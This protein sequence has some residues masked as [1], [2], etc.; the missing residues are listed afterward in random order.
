MIP[1][2]TPLFFGVV[3]YVVAPALWL[4]WRGRLRAS[5]L[6]AAT[7]ALSALQLGWNGELATAAAC[8]GLQL[9]IIALYALVRPRGIPGAHWGAIALVL[10]P[11]VVTRLTGVTTLASPFGFLGISYVTFRVIDV[12]FGLRDG[13]IKQLDG[14]ALVAYLLFFP[15]LSSGPIDRYRRFAADFRRTLSREA[16]LDLLDSAVPLFVRGALYKFVGAALVKEQLVDRLVD[17]GDLLGIGGYMYA[18]TAFLFLDFAGYSAMA[19]ALSRVFGINTP[20]NFNRPFLATNIVEFWN[21]WHISLSTW[22]RDHVYMR[23]VLAAKRGKWFSDRYVPSY[24]ALVVSFGLMGIWHGFA[25]HFVV[26]GL[27]HAMLQ[28]GHSL[29]VRWNAKHRVWG[30][31]RGWRLLGQFVTVNAYCL[32]LLLFSGRLF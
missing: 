32:G 13:A 27:Y 1:Y 4:G 20:E 11:L 15:T 6:L 24:L 29:F 5:F 3:G 16:Y 18:Y 9:A 7:V 14:P 30:E 23:I 25:W 28:I 26:Y 21:R 31:G 19:V 10:L 22:F 2:A 8:L 12:I 17:R